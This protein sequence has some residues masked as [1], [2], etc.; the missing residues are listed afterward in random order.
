MKEFSTE[1]N[2]AMVMAWAAEL[3]QVEGERLV[4]Y[5]DQNRR[6]ADYKAVRFTDIWFRIECEMR[7]GLGFRDKATQELFDSLLD[8][9]SP[10]EA[11]ERAVMIQDRDDDRVDLLGQMALAHGF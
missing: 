10:E 8:G 1:Q 9:K 7:E 2:K 5:L 11:Y 3:V 4:A 6:L